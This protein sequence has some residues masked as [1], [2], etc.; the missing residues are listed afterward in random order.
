M[1]KLVLLAIISIASINLFGQIDTNTYFPH[2]NQ[3][4]LPQIYQGEN[5]CMSFDMSQSNYTMFRSIEDGGPSPSVK[6]LS[7]YAQPYYT[8]KPLTVIGIAALIYRDSQA[9][10]VPPFRFG[11]MDTNMKSYI[12]IKDSIREQSGSLYTAKFTEYFFYEP[13]NVNGH[14][15]IYAQTPKPGKDGYNQHPEGEVR[16]AATNDKCKENYGDI[17]PKIKTYHYTANCDLHYIDDWTP[18]YNGRV[19]M[20]FPIIGEYDSTLFVAGLNDADIAKFSNVYPNPATSEVTVQSS[21]N[22]ESIELYNMIGQ[23]L[24]TKSVNAYSTSLDVSL[25]PKGN[26]TLLIRTRQ[27][28]AKK[29]LIVQ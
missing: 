3:Y 19:F 28:S 23:L 27:G 25:Y 20:L 6:T 29:K 11:I 1:K 2:V 13:I 8:E 4:L 12:Y 18:E 9:G 21:F 26:Y 10:N 7:D 5:P 15:Y 24:D 16:L 17:L 22:I 14:F